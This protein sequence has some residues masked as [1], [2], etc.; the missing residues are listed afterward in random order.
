MY[1]QITKEI[2]KTVFEN[3]DHMYDKRYPKGTKIGLDS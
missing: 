2:K 1:E 3:D